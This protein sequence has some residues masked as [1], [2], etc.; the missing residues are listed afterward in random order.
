MDRELYY[1]LAIAIVAP[2]YLT[3][4]DAIKSITE[5]RF[6]KGRTKAKR[7]YTDQD[8]EKFLEMQK[9]MTIASIAKSAGETV[10]IIT[11]RLQRYRDKMDPKRIKERREARSDCNREQ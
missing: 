1:A 9:T 4:D 5:G 7:T 10:A 2:E 11:T 8:V 3:P 6:V